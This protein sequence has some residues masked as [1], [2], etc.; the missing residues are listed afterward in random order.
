[1]K[2]K[3]SI[4]SITLLAGIFLFV[5]LLAAAQNDVQ[6]SD[7]SRIYQLNDQAYQYYYYSNLDSC[8]FFALQALQWSDK[9]LGLETVKNNEALLKR[10]KNL[11]AI[12]LTNFARGIENKNIT[13]ARDTLTKALELVKETGNKR[14]EAAI[15][16]AFGTMYDFNGQSELAIQ[17]H[18]K[19]LELIREYGSRSEYAMK[20]TDLAVALRSNGSYG[21]ALDKL[22]ESLKISRELEDTS[23]IIETLLAMGF[24]Y[25]FVEQWDDALS[26]QQEALKIFRLMNDSS[27]IARIYND[28]GVTNMTSGNLDEALRLHRAALTIRLNSTEYYGTFASFVYIGQ[29]LEDFS[30]YEGAVENYKSGL[31]FA[32]KSGYKISIVDG[33]L[34]LG[35]AYMKLPDHEKALH[36]FEAAIKLSKEINDATG[37]ARACMQIAKIYIGRNDH[38]TAL[39]WL[40]QAG[41]VAPKSNLKFLE[42]IYQSLAESYFKIGDPENAYKYILKYS[43]AKDSVITAENLEKITH[44]TNKLEFENKMALQK[45]S[46][47]KMMAIQQGQIN[48]ERLTRNIFLL[49]MLLAV[50]LGI[51][52]LVRFREKQ[53]LN[54][55]LNETLAN[56]RATQTQL[57][58]AEKMASLGELTAGIAHEIQNPLNF[59]NNFSEVSVDLINELREEMAKG[60][61][62]EVDAISGDLQQNLEKIKEHGKRASSIVKGMLEHSRSGSN[63]KVPT[64]LNTLA[65]EYLRLAYHGLRAKDKSFQS[66]FRMQAD[67]TLPNVNVVPQEIGR[68]MLNLI[69]NAFYAVSEKTKAGIN[70]YNPEVIVLTRRLNNTIEIRVTDNGS[71]IPDSVKDKI[72][73]PF[74]TTKPTGQGTGLGLSMSYDII[75]K[76]HGGKLK[77]ESEE[78]IGTVFIIELPT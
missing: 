77:L 21:D 44:L 78:G 22:M 64:D 34:S 33:H 71:G 17:N 9:L 73:Q 16:T 5:G 31:Q 65:D 10:C 40:N 3:E 69:N 74:F 28:M 30:D 42:E 58:H 66:A 27:G 72:F 50:V 15:Y 55:R 51:I 62:Q 24:V 23:T 59:V 57:V 45:E 38:I 8:K 32:I 61:Q 75:T 13:A 7:T 48:R 12:S 4:I 60:D 46:N 39:N 67:E 26:S 53:K 2:L 70:G 43:D 56:L 18:T 76:G 1:M 52:V 49:G 41:E 25:A 14:E 36:Q 6:I 35:G 47:E 63:E 68:V 19:A 54:R 11:K 37:E 29:I 20:L